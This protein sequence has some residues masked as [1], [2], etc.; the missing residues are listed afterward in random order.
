VIYKQHYVVFIFNQNLGEGK[1]AIL[2]KRNQRQIQM[3]KKHSK[4]EQIMTITRNS[5]VKEI[6]G[7][8]EVLAIV[9]KYMP[10]L[11]PDDPRLKPALAMPFKSLCAF[12]ATGISKEKAEEMFKEFEAANI[13]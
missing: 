9:N 5:K 11:N 12:P 3:A 6:I 2:N 1:D 7:N 10:D 8:A 4:G 13:E